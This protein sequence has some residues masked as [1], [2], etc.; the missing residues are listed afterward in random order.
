MSAPDNL[1]EVGVLTRP[2]GIRGEIR[3]NYYAESLDLLLYGKVYLQAG[4]REPRRVEVESVR[5]HGGMPLVRFAEAPDRTSVEVL[6]GQ[7]LL[8]EETSLPEPDEDEVY[9][10]EMLGLDVLLDTDGSRLGTLDHVLFHGE[11]EIWSIV[12]P[13]GREVLL[14]AVPEFVTSIDLDAGSIRIVP[15]EG[16]LELYLGQ[17]TPHT[18]S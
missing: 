9:L 13:E 12:T 15:P 2:H 14:P 7:T 16:L 10:H 3:I 8:V 5:L 18:N 4:N 6:R 1:I 11:Q 17:D